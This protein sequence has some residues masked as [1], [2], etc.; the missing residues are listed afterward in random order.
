MDSSAFTAVAGKAASM[1][2]VDPA[3][4]KHIQE[5]ADSMLKNPE[6]AA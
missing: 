3:T 2:L 6:K 4:L 1:G 5:N